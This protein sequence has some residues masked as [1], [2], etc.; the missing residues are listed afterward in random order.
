M[1]Q[2][3]L[4]NGVPEPALITDWFDVTKYKK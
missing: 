3:K 1:Y 4:V 2:I